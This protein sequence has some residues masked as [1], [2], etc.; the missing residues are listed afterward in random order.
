MTGLAFWR[1]RAAPA[2]GLAAP[3][4]VAKR[5]AHAGILDALRPPRDP[6]VLVFGPQYEM[7][8]LRRLPDDQTQYA[9]GP[10]AVKWTGFYGLSCCWLCGQPVTEPQGDGTT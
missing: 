4:A 7:Q 10:C 9:C 3:A 2:A 6:D 5:Y 8:G 1:D